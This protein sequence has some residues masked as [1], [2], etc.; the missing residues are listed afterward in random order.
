MHPICSGVKI[1]IDTGCGLCVRLGCETGDTHLRRLAET[2]TLPFV[3]LDT[4]I[5]QSTLWFERDARE[6]FITALL[7]A[8]PREILEP[9][10]QLK[11]D[12]IEETGFTVP[13]GWYGF[14]P[15]AGVGIIRQ[16]GIDRDPGI[17]ALT[18]LGSPDQESRSAEYGGRRL[19]RVNGGYV[20]LNYIKY[21]ERD[22][23][24]ADRNRR[25][26]Q[27]QREEK[28]ARVEELRTANVSS[29]PLQRNDVQS[30]VALRNDTPLAN[31]F[32][33]R[34]EVRGQRLEARGQ[35][36]PKPLKPSRAQERFAP[37]SLAELTA[38]IQERKSA[39]DPQRFV[40]FYQSK[41]WKVGNQPMKDWKASVRTWEKRED[42]NKRKRSGVAPS[43]NGLDLKREAVERLK[44]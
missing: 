34:L 32:P 3:K 4:R 19:V 1:F 21:R 15:A 25:W 16:A 38:Y 37:P 5:L 18:E 8:E 24:S 22:V 27:K 13:P 6:L 41:G 7:M 9:V 10:P 35:S 28:E 29:V 14:V 40:D 42:D 43:G 12:A 11:V 23:T 44:R 20:I 36:K 2:V 39:V 30:T 17:K 33:E 31:V 26:R